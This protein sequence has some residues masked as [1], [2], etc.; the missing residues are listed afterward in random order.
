MRSPPTPASRGRSAS[1]PFTAL[2]L[3][4]QNPPTPFT[5][6][7]S[8]SSPSELTWLFFLQE[9]VKGI[10]IIDCRSGPGIHDLNMIFTTYTTPCSD[11]F[12]RHLFLQRFHD[13]NDTVRDPAQKTSFFNC[14][15]S[16]QLLLMH[17]LGLWLSG[18]IFGFREDFSNGFIHIGE[19]AFRQRLFDFLAK[20]ARVRL[21]QRLLLTRKR[22]NNVAEHLD[23]VFCKQSQALFARH[24][25]VPCCHNA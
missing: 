21:H 19:A 3:E 8:S 17:L 9:Q 5:P 4:K 6:S 12:P 22:D 11:N 15:S 24:T 25:P 14:S 18:S 7:I 2:A 23:F 10:I 13:L 16:L 1:T 20:L